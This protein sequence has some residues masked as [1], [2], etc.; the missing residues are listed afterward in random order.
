MT[1]EKQ[2]K[3]FIRSTWWRYPLALFR[4]WKLRDEDGNVDVSVLTEYER[5]LYIS[6]CDHGVVELRK[7]NGKYSD[8][9]YGN[10]IKCKT[11]VVLTAKYK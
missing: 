1:T 3:K 10:C 5:A 11:T 4:F 6:K 7:H 8:A 2:I 9:D